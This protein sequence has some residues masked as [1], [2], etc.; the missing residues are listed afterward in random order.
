MDNAKKISFKEPR[1]TT[2]AAEPIK[3]ILIENTPI[4]EDPD[5]NLQTPSILKKIPRP[6]IEVSNGDIDFEKDLGM[7]QENFER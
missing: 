3:A 1:T 6:A 5:G 2:A 4:V 7:D